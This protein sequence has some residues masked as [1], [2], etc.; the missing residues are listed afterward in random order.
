MKFNIIHVTGASGSG[1]TTLAKFICCKYGYTHLDT[2]DFFWEAIDPPFTVNREITTRQDLML[3]AIERAGKCVISGSLTGWGDIFIPRF[4][5]VIYLYTATELRLKRLRNRELQ[6]FGGRILP[7]G[8][9]HK[10]HEEFIKWAAAYDTG[11]VEMRSAELHR[12]WL[13]QILCPII[14]LNGNLSCDENLKRIE[15]NF[16]LG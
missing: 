11:G 2:D 15:H 5:L 13:K 1:T 9:M 6:R 12:E 7:G 10:E 16:Y 14:E 4:N 8:D 3:E